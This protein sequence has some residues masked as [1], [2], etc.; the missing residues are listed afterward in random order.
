MINKSSHFLIS[1]INYYFDRVCL[2]KYV[3]LWQKGHVQSVHVSTA[4]KPTYISFTKGK[5][6][7]NQDRKKKNPELGQK[8]MAVQI[9][10]IIDLFRRFRK[11]RK[12]SDQ[13]PFQFSRMKSNKH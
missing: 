7:F 8:N 4:G 2:V 13:A 12:N 1:Y 11:K 3:A 9:L 10:H 5:M 6:I